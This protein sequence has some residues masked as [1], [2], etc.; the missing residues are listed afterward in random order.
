MQVHREHER[1]FLV[2]NGA[3]NTFG[4]GVGAAL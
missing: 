4:G 2:L 1:A 3:M